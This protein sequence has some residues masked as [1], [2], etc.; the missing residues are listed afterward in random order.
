MTVGRSE[1]TRVA[2]SLGFLALGVADLTPSTRGSALDR[3]LA[4]GYAG[5]MRYLHRQAA[6]RKAPGDIVP[7]A[8]VAVVVLDNYF[9]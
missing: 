4:A 7:G 5:T 3:W 8:T 9:P 2:E 6:M 1:L